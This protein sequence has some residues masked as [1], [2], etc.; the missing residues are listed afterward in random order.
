MAS[1]FV[2]VEEQMETKQDLYDR[3]SNRGV[4]EGSL[5]GDTPDARES[6][7]RNQT[8]LQLRLWT[9]GRSE[10]RLDFHN[11]SNLSENGIFIETTRPY[12]LQTL[13]QIEFNLPGVHDPIRVTGRVVSKLDE[14]NAGPN[15]MGNGFTFVHISDAERS[16][17]ETF[18]G[19]SQLAGA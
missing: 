19:A 10:G 17:I 4:P 11:C 5:D 16:L 3:R 1:E 7:R 13:V 8:R 14:D 9:E 12:P 6:Q 18:V 2:H 15:I